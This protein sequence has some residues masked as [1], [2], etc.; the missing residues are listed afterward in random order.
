[1]INKWI[2]CMHKSSYQEIISVATKQAHTY[3]YFISKSNLDL[4]YVD[5]LSWHHGAMEGTY[6]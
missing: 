4:F 6:F 5:H 2:K 1:M 3:N